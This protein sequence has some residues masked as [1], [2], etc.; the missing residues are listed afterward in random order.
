MKKTI[1]RNS[2][3]LQSFAPC[4]GLYPTLHKSLFD[5]ALTISELPFSPVDF[6]F[7]H[8]D[9]AVRSKVDNSATVQEYI[10]MLDVAMHFYGVL[11]ELF[12][13]GLLTGGA[14]STIDIT[15]QYRSVRTNSLV[16]GTP[17]SL[18]RYGLAIDVKAPAYVLNMLYDAYS[19]YFNTFVPVTGKVNLYPK[20]LIKYYVVD[21]NS[22]SYLHIG[23]AYT[24]PSLKNN[25][26]LPF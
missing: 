16:G 5:Y 19:K 12:S 18:H 9:V 25:N 2:R 15:S 6:V 14:I 1:L 8:S 21:E 4:K 11:E 13:K 3:D 20:E 17:N 23:F 24:V 7:D 26:V 10:R 22:P